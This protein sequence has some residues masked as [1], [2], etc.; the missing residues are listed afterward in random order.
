MQHDG[1]K[2]AGGE[3]FENRAIHVPHVICKD[4]IEVSYRLMQVKAENEA[5]WSHCSADGE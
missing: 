5:D 4:V 1:E 2:A 3:M